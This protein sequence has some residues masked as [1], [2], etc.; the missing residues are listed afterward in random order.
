MHHPFT[1]FQ[2]ALY[3]LAPTDRERAQKLGV[4]LRTIVEY[5]AGRLPRAL[6]TLVHSTA[7]ADALAR[8]A[9]QL[10]A[11]PTLPPPAAPDATDAPPLP[12]S[13]P[14]PTTWHTTGDGLVLSTTITQHIRRVPDAHA[15]AQMSCSAE[16][17]AGHPDADGAAAAL[18]A[19]QWSGYDPA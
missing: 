11:Y 8:D 14:L 5:R 15:D 9:Q 13:V 1:H 16:Q 19:S 6:Y 12:G 2:Q 4:S 3:A 17:A 10:R 7:L 18:D